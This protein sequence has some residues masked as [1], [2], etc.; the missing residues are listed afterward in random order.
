MDQNLEDMTVEEFLTKKTRD[1]EEVLLV[2][3]F[4]V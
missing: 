3:W 4:S 1:V 2:F